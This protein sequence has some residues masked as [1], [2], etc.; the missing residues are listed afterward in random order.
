MVSF[1]VFLKEKSVKPNELKKGDRVIDTNPNCK[2]YKSKGIVTAVKKIKG[3]KGNVVGNKVEYKCTNK[4]SC[5]KRND[6]L[7][8][9]EVQLG[10]QN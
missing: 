1:R 2:H 5:W 4:G 8:K 3:K 7:E 10:K 9:T 6:K